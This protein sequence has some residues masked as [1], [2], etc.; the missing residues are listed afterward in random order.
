MLY[1]KHA[2]QC[3]LGF[4]HSS[5][6]YFKASTMELIL[7]DVFYNVDYIILIRGDYELGSWI[8]RL[9]LI[10]KNMYFVLA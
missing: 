2:C 9:Y 10:Y 3:S 1:P 6:Y 5:R 8:N 7:L 4:Y